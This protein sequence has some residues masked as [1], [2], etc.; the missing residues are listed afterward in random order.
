MIRPKT[1]EKV[2]VSVVAG[3]WSVEDVDHLKIPGLVIAVNDAA[4]YLSRYD[5]AVSMDRLWLTGRWNTMMQNR[6]PLYARAS[7]LKG[8][9]VPT[10]APSWLRTFECDRAAHSFSFHP[11]ALNG[12]N[13][14]T[15]ALNYAHT[16]RPDLLYLFGFDMCRHPTTQAPYW[17]PVYPWA[18]PRGGTKDGKYAEWSREFEWVKNEFDSIG[19]SVYNVSP[20]SLVTAFHKVTP[21]EAGVARV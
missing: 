12:S 13:S 3:G 17:Y 21:S 10:P 9:P 11:S 1:R 2:I 19:T 14:G 4:L 18:N 6:R 20:R 15:C 16:L 7:A 5:V 8:V